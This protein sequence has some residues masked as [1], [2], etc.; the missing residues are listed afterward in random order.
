MAMARPQ[1]SM[2]EMEEKGRVVGGKLLVVRE[3]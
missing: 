1:E 3:G 2:I